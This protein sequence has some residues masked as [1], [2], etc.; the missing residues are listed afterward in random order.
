M[1]SHRVLVHAGALVAGTTITLDDEESNHLRVRRAEHGQGARLFDGAGVTATGVLA[2]AGKGWQ[3]AVESAEHHAPQSE[4]IL[5]VGAGDRDRFLS[6]AE[7]CTELGV[8][9]LIPL[10]TERSAQVET[11][12]RESGV[13]RCRKRAR[14]ACKQSG[15]PWATVVDDLTR[16]DALA[17]AYPDVRWMLADPHGAPIGSIPGDIAAG[18]L[19]GPEG[20]FSESET[21][22]MVSGLGASRVQ[23]T[24][25]VMRFE[26]AAVVAAGVRRILK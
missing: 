17:G 21:A 12:L 7:K 26:T 24:R 9:R 2:K 16:M 14:E 25:H 22:A 6:L 23:L 13:E 15:N 11:R 18:W 5:A 20:G 1:S 4:L 19:I 8:T 3:V 10:I